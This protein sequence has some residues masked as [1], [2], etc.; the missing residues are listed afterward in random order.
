MHV[1]IGL[2]SFLQQ[3]V[4]EKHMDPHFYPTSTEI[5]NIYTTLHLLY[6]RNINQHGRARWWKR[7]SILKRT[8]YSLLYEIERADEDGD[9]EE[10]VRSKMKRLK[11]SVIPSCYL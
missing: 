4:S 2:A 8:I 11:I 1:S 5:Q 3:H 9:V 10:Y 6:R 7:L